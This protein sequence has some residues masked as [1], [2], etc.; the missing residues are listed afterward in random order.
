[1][2]I[3][4]MILGL[5][6]AQAPRMVPVGDAGRGG[7]AYEYAISKYEITNQQYVEFLNAVARG[8]DENK[9]YNPKMFSDLKGG[10]VRHTD[11]EGRHSYSTKAYMGNKPVNFVNWCSA[12]RFVN[13]LHNGMP[14]G[15]QNES[16]TEDGAYRLLPGCESYART[17]R[18]PQ[19]RWA[20]PSLEEM[21]KAAFFD[22]NKYSDRGGF[23]K[24]A[25]R[26]DDQL[27]I[28]AMASID[29]WAL[30]PG[31]NTVNYGRSANWNG[32]VGGNVLSVGSGGAQSASS[33]G[34]FDQQG[35]VAEWSDTILIIGP[36]RG[37]PMAYGNYSAVWRGSHHD[38]FIHLSPCGTGGG[39]EAGGGKY[40]SP[41][42]GFRVVQLGPQARAP[43]MASTIFDEEPIS[44][45]KI[46]FVYE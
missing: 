18:R 32:S 17:H 14:S 3:L 33:Y 45:E 28:E 36:C 23:W 37:C 30:N 27:P 25:T 46:L 42:T 4:M 10:I 26:S 15:S 6:T 38:L 12:A 16:T 40:S 29:G 24:L 19:A 13:W 1:M 34:T 8:S 39:G 22:P 43:R 9:L 20:L 2:K 7:V 41:G 5:F 35:N 11:P 44:Q 31:T 21:K